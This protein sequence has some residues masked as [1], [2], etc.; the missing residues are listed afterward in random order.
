MRKRMSSAILAVLTSAAMLATVAG[1]AASASAATTTSRGKFTNIPMN[2]QCKSLGHLGSFTGTMTVTQF[3]THNGHLM[4]KGT[5]KG[6]CGLATAPDLPINQ[7]VTFP[8][9]LPTHTCK[10][11]VLDLGPLHL[12]LLGLVIDLAPVHLR[13]TAQEGPGNLLGN[14]LC[15]I[16]HLLDNHQQLDAIAPLLNS[17]LALLG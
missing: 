4:G 3:M 12:D 15:D 1:T 6:V 2:G 10:I 16:A 9:S 17:I 13:I 11:L 8:V 14:L 7:A 5:L